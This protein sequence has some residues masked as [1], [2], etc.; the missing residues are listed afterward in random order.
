MTK[1]SPAEV[2]GQI[3]A[4]QLVKPKKRQHVKSVCTICTKQL[5]FMLSSCMK[6][7]AN[8]IKLHTTKR[9]AYESIQALD[10]SIPSIASFH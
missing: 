6:C 5:F 1:F 9:R 7:G 8:E 3:Q 10:A 4:T 2:C